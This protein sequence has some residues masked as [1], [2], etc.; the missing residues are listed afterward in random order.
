M[1]A[2]DWEECANDSFGMQIT[3]GIA[4]MSY[5]VSNAI[6]GLYMAAVVTYSFGVLLSDDETGEFNMSTVPVRGLILKMELPFNS[7]RFPAYVLVMVVQFFQLLSV[8][9]AIAALNVLILTLVSHISVEDNILQF[10][11]GILGKKL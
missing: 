10:R 7:S 9:C 4:T 1:I 5:R 2:T 11:S 8:A 6:I 3:T